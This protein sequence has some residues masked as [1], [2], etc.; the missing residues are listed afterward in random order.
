LFWLP[1]IEIWKK[2]SMNTF[3]KRMLLFCAVTVCLAVIGWLIATGGCSDPTADSVDAGGGAAKQ[4][5][6]IKIDS[7]DVEI[8]LDGK[9]TDIQWTGSNS[10]GQKPSGF[11]Y[12]LS[13]KAIVDSATDQLKSLEIT[14]DMNGVK[15]MAESLTKKLKYKGFF[16]VDKYPESK[17]VST[18]VSHEARPGDPAGT[19]CV[20]EGNF[21][22]RDVTQSITIPVEVVKEGDAYKI[23]SQFK[24]NRRD[25]GVVYANA[26]GDKLIRD[27]VLLS[28]DIDSLVE[29]AVDAK[30]AADVAKVAA[31]QPQGDYTETINETLVEFE[32]V[33]VP[34]DE[35]KN[36]AP[37]YIGKTEVTWDE[38]DYWALCKGMPAK[39]SIEEISN[40]LRPSAPH[41]LGKV[42]RGWGRDGQP[43]VGV[44]RLSAEL[45]C[46]WLS[47]QTG[48]TYRLPTPDEW[49]RAF[50]MGGDDLSATLESDE[51]EKRAWFD[52]NALAVDDEGFDQ[53]RAMPVGQLSPNELGIHDM[54]GNAS[55]W[56]G[57]TGDE[58][59]VRGGH[60][61]MS[62]DE[63]KGSHK[64]A[65]DQDI[66]NKDYPQEPKSKWWYVNADF[67]GF[68]VVCEP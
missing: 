55:E 41:D 45:Y 38:F 20:V 64:E 54:L 49:D 30:P 35:G 27:N 4:V 11:F 10:A 59:I 67:V 15:A 23:Q 52:E 37:F 24:L 32:M 57:G 1:K 9:N 56:V 61:K 42:Y 29:D 13:G 18:S 58:H 19:N 26:A 46:K 25:Y 53:E 28:I 6:D 3:V 14:I 50:E 33:L 2:E 36:I 34:G 16:E 7:T 22:L 62:S 5:A 47:E 31:D 17:F 44:S 21:Q 12:E 40:Q 60:F 65:E 51:L 48:K 68:R 66:W 43:V 39:E 8:V 63:L